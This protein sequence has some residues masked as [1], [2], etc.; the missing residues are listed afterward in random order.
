M[1]GYTSVAVFLFSAIALVVPSGF[2]LGAAMLCFGSVALL[3][4]PSRPPLDREDRLLVGAFLFYF[5]VCASTSLLHGEPLREYD[6]PLRFVLAI[7]AL[8][9]LRVRPPAPGA[10][11]AGLIVGATGSGLMAGWENLALGETRA[12]G[13][14]NPIQ[15]GNICLLLGVLCLAGLGWAASQRRARA[16]TAGLLAAAAIGILG[17]LCTGSR[18]SWVGLPVCIVLLY[19]CY[20]TAVRRYVIAGAALAVLGFA[21]LYAVPQTGMQTRL[22]QAVSETEGYFESHEADT[23]VGARWEMWRIAIV[24]YPEHPWLGWGKEGF[25]ARKHQLIREGKAAAFTWDHTHSHNEYL[26]AAVKRGILGLLGVLVL[27]GVPLWLFARRLRRDDPAARPY[28]LAGVL[29]LV[30][31]LGFGLTQA[32]LTHNNGVMTLA[33]MQVILWSLLRAASPVPAA[34]A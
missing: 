12:G 1:P 6:V 22:D 24:I 23:S 31:Y 15:Y 21:A 10:F 27:Y 29:L 16:W 34:P 20:G 9:L 19:R 32:F 3:F 8:L 4:L 26:D 28:A 17:S 30:C 7:P 33:F 13:F 18:G 14:T 2:S 25:M 5:A 11:W